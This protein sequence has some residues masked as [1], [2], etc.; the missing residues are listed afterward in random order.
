MDDIEI[1]IREFGFTDKELKK[2]HDYQQRD[3]KGTVI[4]QLKGLKRGFYIMVL[5]YS[6]LAIKWGYSLVTGDKSSIIAF[7]FILLLFAF[8]LYIAAPF[9]LTFKSVRFLKK[10]KLTGYL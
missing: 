8:A 4:Y 1:K 6:L 2:F 7:S 5:L 10:H 3:D 9:R